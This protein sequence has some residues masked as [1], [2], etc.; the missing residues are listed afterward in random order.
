MSSKLRPGDR[1]GRLR[2]AFGALGVAASIVV[3]VLVLGALIPALP[4]VGSFGSVVG[5][6][7]FEFALT[8][9]LVVLLSWMAWRSQARRSAICGLA[10]GSITLLGALAVLGA[11][12]GYAHSHG[13]DVGFADVVQGGRPMP[14]P[15]RTV[16][17]GT[18]Q[19]EPLRAGIWLPRNDSGA[20]RPAV[21]WI[22]GGGFVGGNRDEQRGIFRYLADHG[23]PVISIDYRLAPPVRWRDASSDVVCAMS[24]L[25]E[26]GR[27]LGIDPGRLV[28]SGASAGGSL[29]L[30]AAYGSG[31]VPS[32]CGGPPPAPPLAVAGFYPAADLVG[33]WQD[34]G[35]YGYA[36]RVARAYLGGGPAEYPQRYAYASPIERVRPGLMP[37]LLV[38]GG[39]DHL[40]LPERVSAVADRL[41]GNGN[42]VTYREFPFGYHAF[43][44][45]G[46]GAAFSRSTM[47]DFLRAHAPIPGS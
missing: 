39:N 31:E 34:D 46:I 23:Y 17:F 27:G 28:L 43:D 19:G 42:A 40:I 26:H 7:P 21:V 8:G 37:T 45:G 5:R 13:A 1:G 2:G 9:L 22:H 4:V 10:T 6:R 47:L 35:L 30:N 18:V 29:S 25:T 3:A 33:N 12:L 14:P 20:A 41:R 36:R 24:W 15:D 44:A 32:S 38:T 16:T 11:Q